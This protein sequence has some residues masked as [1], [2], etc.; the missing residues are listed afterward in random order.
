MVNIRNV[1]TV[2]VDIWK[3]A[4]WY[5]PLL[6]GI[7]HTAIGIYHMVYTMQYTMIYSMVYTVIYGMVYMGGI[8]L[9]I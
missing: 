3:V 9:G 8:Y 2:V 6:D 5:N 1:P 4:S 7:Y